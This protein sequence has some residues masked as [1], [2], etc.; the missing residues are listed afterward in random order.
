M[1]QG[2]GRWPLRSRAAPSSE[3]TAREC[4]GIGACPARGARRHA[5]HAQLTVS[6][7]WRSVTHVS[8]EVAAGRAA[9]DPARLDHA[10]A[11]PSATGDH[12]ECYRTGRHP[13][14]TPWP[15][16]TGSH[17]PMGSATA[18]QRRLLTP[19]GPVTAVARTA[20]GVERSTSTCGRF[21]NCWRRSRAAV[22]A[23]GAAAGDRRRGGRQVRAR[24]AVPTRRARTSSACDGRSPTLRGLVGTSSEQLD[25]TGRRGPLSSTVSLGRPHDPDPALD[26]DPLISSRR[27]ITTIVPSGSRCTVTRTP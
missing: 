4:S 5:R 2:E 15:G 11:S 12:A 9:R 22:A 18:R 25:H 10:V 20:N 27:G 1:R 21:P 16:T 17:R 8:P 6:P 14:S 24:A 13:G 3:T 19:G 26:P 7:T 23:R